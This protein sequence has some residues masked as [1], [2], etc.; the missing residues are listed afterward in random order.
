MRAKLLAISVAAALA[1]T[2]VSAQNTDIISIDDGSI[3]VCSSLSAAQTMY[4]LA[5]NNRIQNVS[6]C[7]AVDAPMEVIVLQS[8]HRISSI[9]YRRFRG[10]DVIAQMI[11]NGLPAD[12]EAV[13]RVRDQPWTEWYRSPAW[14][15]TAWLQPSE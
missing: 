11:A 5:V 15:F 8:G 10:E 7:W 4:S 12:G 13:R 14:A 9:T 3:I 6:G 1:A 2:T